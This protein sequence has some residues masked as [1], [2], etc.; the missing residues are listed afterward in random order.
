MKKAI[1]PKTAKEFVA[2][3]ALDAYLANETLEEGV[4]AAI[5]PSRLPY[6]VL[7]VYPVPKNAYVYQ[8]KR[9]R[10]TSVELR[11]PC[12][13]QLPCPVPTFEVSLEACVS[14]WVIGKNGSDTK[15]KVSFKIEVFSGK[16]KARDIATLYSAGKLS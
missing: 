1:I 6:R 12:I 10:C 13:D 2:S 7:E 8:G 4:S 3:L 16:F 14:G 11:R 9:F 15:K 5:L